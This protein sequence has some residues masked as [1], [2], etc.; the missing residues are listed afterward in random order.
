MKVLPKADEVVI[1]SEKFLGYSLNRAKNR[2]KA[3][4]FET[5]LGYDVNNADELIDNIRRNIKKFPAIPK[6]NTGY[7]EKYAVLMEL[8][9]A[10]GKTANV[11][12]A[13]IDDM[14]TGDMRLTNAYVKK[15]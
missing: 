8:T 6:G 14:A 4:A 13:W 7:G 15:R 12:T 9:G 11:L 10:N 5:A 1:P 3:I 2:D